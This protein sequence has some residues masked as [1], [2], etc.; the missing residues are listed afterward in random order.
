MPET[1][2]PQSSA[3]DH[4]RVITVGQVPSDESLKVTVGAE[5]LSAAV[6]SPVFVGSV[7][8]SHSIVVLAGMVSTGAEVSCTVINCTQELPLPLPSVTAHVRVMI[9]GQAPADESLKVAAGLASQA[10]LIVGLPVADGSVEASHSMVVL[11]GQV[12]L[13]TVVSSTVTVKPHVAEFEP[14]DAVQVTVLGPDGNVLPD[15]GTQDTAGLGSQLSDA[16]ALA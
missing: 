11:A 1:G 2:F 13:G 16:V 15:A 8:A 10:S 4:V 3:A 14:S 5:Q 7:E 6:A 12:M 9:A